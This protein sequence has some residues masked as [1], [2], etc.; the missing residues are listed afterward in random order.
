MRTSL[1]R[2]LKVEIYDQFY[3]IVQL[4]HSIVKK[5]IKLAKDEAVALHAY[6]KCY[7]PFF[8]TINSALRGGDYNHFLIKLI[9]SALSKLPDY[10][11]KIVYRW[12]V[13][14]LDERRSL[15]NNET[16]TEHAYLSTLKL[17]NEL[18]MVES[19]CLLLKINHL[20]G[21]D[22]ALYSDDYSADIQEVLI[23][24]GGIFQKHAEPD[25]NYDLDIMQI[26]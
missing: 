8:I 17:P 7:P 20:N 22:I 1:V 5:D 4:N 23:P 14:T 16:I 10:D 26:Q 3:S 11:E 15:E 18:T 19:D 12:A 21:K 2:F 6:T 25:A 24:R 13:P 9:D